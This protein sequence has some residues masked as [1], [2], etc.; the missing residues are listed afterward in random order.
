LFDSSGNT[1]DYINEDV[2]DTSNQDTTSSNNN[3]DLFNSG[4][5]DDGLFDFGF[6]HPTYD[7]LTLDDSNS[8]SSNQESRYDLPPFNQNRYIVS[9]N[10]ETGAIDATTTTVATP[11]NLAKIAENTR[12]SKGRTNLY[13]SIFSEFPTGGGAGPGAENTEIRHP[14]EICEDRFGCE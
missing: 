8:D 2:A 10:T 9:G 7:F 3:D 14:L 12:T 6:N 1:E 11:N 13:N 5:Q 4:S